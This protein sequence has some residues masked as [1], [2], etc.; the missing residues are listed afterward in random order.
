M[1]LSDTIR[2]TLRQSGGN[3]MRLAIKISP[4]FAAA[5]ARAGAAIVLCTIGRFGT[6]PGAPPDYRG[7]PAYGGGLDNIRYSALD[8]II[9]DNVRQLAVAWT[10]DSGDAY[11]DL[12]MG[13]N[14]ICRPRDATTPKLRLIALDAATGAL[15]WSFEPARGQIT[16]LGKLRNCGRTTGRAA[17]T[18][19]CSTQPGNTSMLAP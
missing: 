2:A 15:R 8:Q 10:H 18:T 6:A 14:P 13:C 17:A 19:G 11:R 12:Q 16:T 4:L 9:R 3:A 5:A 7:W 1:I